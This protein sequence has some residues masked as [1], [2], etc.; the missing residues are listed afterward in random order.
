M[1]H[2]LMHIY[3][4]FSIHSFGLLLAI[5]IIIAISLALRHPIRKKIMSTQAFLDAIAIAVIAGLVGAR[6][7]FLMQNWTD[8][9]DWTDIFTIWEGG[10]SILGA[11]IGILVVMPFYM[12]SRKVPFLPFLD[13]IALHA[14]LVQSIARLG[15]FLAGCCFGAP[16]QA[17]W[18]V[19]YTD[20]ESF[21]PLCTKLHPTQVYSSVLLLCIFLFLYFV[22][23]YRVKKPGQLLAL[24]LFLISIERFSVDFFRGDREFSPLSTFF[25]LSVHQLIA[26]FIALTALV[27]FNRLQSDKC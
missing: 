19:T 7:L 5:G 15:C 21:A 17:G 1:R 8:L 16:T 6:L 25:G 9:Q 10:L 23:Q 26:I 3:G 27:I 24:Y 2:T 4:P 18:G 13:L 20:L 12:Q 14:P 11:V 22:A